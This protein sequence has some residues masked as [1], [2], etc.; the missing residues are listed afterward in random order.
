MAY[1]DAVM[2]ELAKFRRLRRSALLD[3]LSDAD[4][5][6]LGRFC[7]IREMARGATVYR[8]GDPAHSV[9]LLEAG[10]VKLSRVARN[11]KEVNLAVLGEADLFGELALGAEQLCCDTVCVV[12]D[13]VVCGFRC[14]D[15]ELF[16]GKQPELALRMTKLI[17]ARLKR[18]ES[19]IQ[20]ILFK[21]VRTRL[22]HTMARL[23]NKFG[24]K[25]PEGTRI[26]MRLTQTDLAHLIGS[27]RETT[28]TIFNEF[29][30][31]GL[32][33][34]DGRYIIVHDIDVLR[35]Y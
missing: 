2:G 24:E 26:S 35:A 29:R 20:D 7:E 1:S 33:G 15:L 10:S 28:S 9:Y 31:E 22:A 11:D 30:R 8:A 4:L 18:V 19:R 5:R 32:I 13:A 12:E 27:T 25:V 34:S 6:T 16:L 3:C 23:A 14:P 17:G 21:D